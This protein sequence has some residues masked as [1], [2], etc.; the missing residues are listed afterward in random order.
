[1]AVSAALGTT[2][3]TDEA[4]SRFS[5]VPL[6][7]KPTPGVVTFVGLSVAHAAAIAIAPSIP[8]IAIGLWWSA[9]T[10]A[11]N[12]I[13]RP[14]FRARV[15][16]RLFSAWL[17]LVLGL[18]QR[19][20]RDRHLAHHAG[21]APR[22]RWS[23]QLA[24]ETTLV[25][26]LW[27]TAAMLAP[28]LFVTVYLPGWMIGLALCQLHGHYEHAHGTTSHYGRLY[29]LLFFN[30]GYHVEHHRRP[31]ADWRALA[32]AGRA[33][34]QPS[35]WPPVLRWLESFDPLSVVRAP[36]R[37]LL[38][39]LERIVMRSPRL[40]QFVVSVHERA[41]RR[42]LTDPDLAS[43]GR[44]TVVGGG[45]FPRTALVLGR[46]A[47]RAR[48]TIV[49]GCQPH[50]DAA[51]AFLRE[52]RA[53]FVHEHFDPSHVCDADLVVIPLAFEGD[54]RVVYDRPPARLVAVHDWIW[55][56]RGRSIVISWLL[57]KR[58]NLIGP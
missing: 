13:H 19:I 56:K 20:W 8:L 57:L 29:N 11:H 15:A 2:H 22:L 40:Q 42:L 23:A 6:H 12:F 34:A 9:N 4:G 10:I 5:G 35:R 55:A 1:M 31:H 54:R 14:F 43:A 45:L 46:I 47:P 39:A 16:N 17:S 27:T 50:L 44:I 7:R 26:A 41:F 36:V 49:D 3:R 37:W 30:D 53:T 21:L 24:I 38:E 48:L 52:A 33:D 25:L 32:A 51:E 28:R 58:L 18:P